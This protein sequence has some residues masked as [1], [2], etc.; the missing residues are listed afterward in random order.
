LVLPPPRI[1]RAHRRIPLRRRGTRLLVPLALL[2][3]LLTLPAAPPEPKG[4]LIESR[5][6]WGRAPQNSHP[7]L[8]YHRDRWFC[9]LRESE[10]SGPPNGAVRIISS[11]DGR[12]WQSAALLR[13]PE[14][15]LYHP[16][17]QAGPGGRMFLTVEANPSASAGHPPRSLVWVSPDGREWNDPVPAAQDGIRLRSPRW[18]LNRSYSIGFDTWGREPV[19]LYS[20]SDGGK[21]E[22]HADRMAAESARLPE[23]V[24][25]FRR[26]GAA[27]GFLGAGTEALLG[28]SRPPYRAWSW[29]RLESGLTIRAMTELEDGRIVAVGLRPGQDGGLALAWLDPQTALC[30]EFLQFPASPDA[31]GAGL[32]FHQGSLWFAYSSSHEGRAMIYLAQASL[33]PLR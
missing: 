4:R 14:S 13:V 15:G 22:I 27:L 33:P 17:L 23:A 5:M 11:P 9:A 29:R 24:L 31:T 16:S 26:D 10:P 20:S 8:I 1:T 32:V 19:R 3:T 25:L 21:Y 7:D 12:V 30:K 2:V 18:R 28:E 6:I